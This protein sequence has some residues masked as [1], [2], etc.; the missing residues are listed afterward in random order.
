MFVVNLAPSIY[1]NEDERPNAVVVTLDIVPI[2][3]LS[4]TASIAG[5]AIYLV[6]LPFTV[7]TEENRT[8]AF[9][10]LVADPFRYT[11]VRPLGIFDWDYREKT[12]IK[13]E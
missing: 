13:N 7:L 11:F 4:L 9:E 10:A 8:F 1:A 12:E 5:S 6:T 3:V 2:R